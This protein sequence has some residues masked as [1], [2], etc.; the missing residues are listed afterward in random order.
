MQLLAVILKQSCKFTNL[1]KMKR[2]LLFITYFLIIFNGIET[3]LLSQNSSSIKNYLT[4]SQIELITQYGYDFPV[5]TQLS[6][7]FIKD[8]EVSYVGLI[9]KQ[10][11]LVY[12]NNKDSVFEIGS[13]TKLF[14]SALLSDLAC[15]HQINIDEAIVNTLPYKL[16]QLEKNSNQITFKTLSNHTSGLPRMPDNYI[17]FYDSALLRDYLQNKLK[18]NSVPGEKYQYSNLGAG[19]LGYL[20]EIKTGKTY[21]ELLQ[22]KIFSKYNMNSTSSDINNVQN[23]VV[24]GRDFLGQII[25]NYQTNILKA[26]GGILTNVVDLSKFVFANFSN[27]T[28]LSFQ[29]QPTYKSDNLDIALGWHIIKY[30]GNSC[31]W[32]HHNGGMEGYS[33]SLFMDLSTKCAVILLSNVSCNHPKTENIAKMC[34]D[35]LKQLYI[36]KIENTSSFTGAPFLELALK[37]GWGTNKDDSIRQLAKSD[38]CIIG[39]W[40]K[41]VAGRTVTRTFMPDNKVQTDIFGNSEID[42]WGYYQLK[43]NQIT[44]RDIGGA[45]CNSTGVYDFSIINDKL[46]FKP[47]NDSCDGRKNGLSGIWTRKK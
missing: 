44:F 32:Y 16:N 3:C 11:S 24:A 10:D 38:T 29:R 26:S 40:Q 25:P 14:T 47:I 37:K 13:I 46:G 6:M 35:L 36:S 45:A 8:N 43:N 7:A 19:L 39:V 30:G 21:E 18:L 41:R 31:I 28:I 42:V 22:E 23:L 2:K 15:H 4:K 9:K 1:K 12:L 5:N 33:S 17:T 34:Q 27:D 20:L